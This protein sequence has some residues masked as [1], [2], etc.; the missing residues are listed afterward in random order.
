M[1]CSRPCRAGTAANSILHASFL[2]GFIIPFYRVDN[3]PISGSRAALE[4][5]NKLLNADRVC[6]IMG[7]GVT[8]CFPRLEERIPP[9]RRNIPA[10]RRQRVNV[11]YPLGLVDTV[12]VTFGIFGY[13][14]LLVLYVPV[15]VI[16]GWHDSCLYSACVVHPGNE[17]GITKCC[18]SA[19][20][21]G[22]GRSL[23]P[24]SG[25]TPGPA[26]CGRP[27]WLVSLSVTARNRR[28]KT[29]YAHSGSHM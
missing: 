29:F 14:H 25:T 3:V 4:H 11:G 22:L 28:G 18:C 16:Q 8:H 23:R 13:A 10:G 19:G 9:R 21:R 17:C 5:E 15:L 7:N 12:L 6:D 24:P 27:V 1:F 26:P 2:G 20:W